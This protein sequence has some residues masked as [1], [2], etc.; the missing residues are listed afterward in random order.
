MSSE[1]KVTTILVTG[2]DRGL[3]LEVVKKLIGHS[4]DSN[5]RKILLACRNLEKGEEAL[6]QLNSP[7]NVHLLQLDISSP[8]SIDQATKEIKEKHGGYLDILINNAGISKPGL[9]IDVARETFAV[10]YFGTKMVN[11]YLIPLLRENGRVVNVSSEVGSWTL[12]ETSDNLQKEYS[13][14]TLTIEQLDH[15]VQRFLSSIEQG[16]LNNS[17]YNAQ[18]LYIVYGMSK[19]AV[20]ALTQILARQWSEKKNLLVLS[21]C[22]GYC[23]TDI[24]HHDPAA[25]SPQIGADSILYAVNAKRDELENGG[26]Y[27]DGKKKAQAFPCAMDLDIVNQNYQF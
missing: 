17:G 1:R 3:G 13:S 6:K 7:R 15:L 19:A 24:N 21:V 16:T 25:R 12:H 14:P 22:P 4:S 11:E 23:S 8:Q 18:S 20:I 26:F 5:K 10:N 27:Q 9:T 2:A